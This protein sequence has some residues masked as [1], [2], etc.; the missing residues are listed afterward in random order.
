MS[1]VLATA[2]RAEVA[3]ELDR[4]AWNLPRRPVQGIAGPN[5]GATVQHGLDWQGFLAL[6]FPGRR[7][8]DLEALTAYGAYRSSPDVDEPDRTEGASHAYD[9]SPS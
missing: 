9:H 6:Y 1:Q 2:E 3:A 7:R 5:H 8:H 4:V